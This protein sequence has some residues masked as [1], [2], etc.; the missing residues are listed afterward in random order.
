MGVSL[1]QPI[2]LQ[3]HGILQCDIPMLGKWYPIL[4]NNWKSSHRIPPES[5]VQNVKD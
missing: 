1:K 4:K 2:L 5:S 3:Q